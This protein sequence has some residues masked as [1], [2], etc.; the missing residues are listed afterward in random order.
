MPSATERLLV[1]VHGSSSTDLQWTRAGHDHGA[2]LARDLGYTPVY[3]RYNS[4]LHISTNGRTLS[5]LLEVLVNAWPARCAEITLLGHS[6]GGGLVARSAHSGE[7]CGWRRQLPRLV[8]LGSPH[9]GAPLERWGSV[10]ERLLDLSA[11]SAPVGRLGRI[12]SAGLTDLRFGNV[13]DDD[14]NDRSRFSPA[15]DR[16]RGLPL[17]DEVDCFAVAGTTATAMAQNLPG[18][19]LVPVAS[20]LG[21]HPSSPDLTLAF[22]S[23]HQC[24]ALGTNHLGLLHREA[25]YDKLRSWLT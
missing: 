6:M 17:P 1:L 8:C 18:D 14:W 3:V 25:V 24:I 23:E 20:A 10:V 2:A 4:G 7:T 21:R 12:R 11:Y 19:G 5:S 9:H 16:R 13:L 15:G 22:P